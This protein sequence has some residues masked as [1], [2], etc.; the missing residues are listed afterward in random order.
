[1]AVA[2]LLYDSSRSA[3]EITMKTIEKKPELLAEAFQLCY[4]N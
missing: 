2:S 3:I 1:M 4:E